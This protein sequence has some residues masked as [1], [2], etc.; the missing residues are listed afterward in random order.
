MPYLRSDD[1]P[2][3]RQLLVDFGRRVRRARRHRGFSQEDLERRSRVDQTAIS[4]LERGLAP[5]MGARRLVRLGDALGP[6]L[7]LG[8]CPHDHECA[9]SAP[10]IHQ[11]A[12]SDFWSNRG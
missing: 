2:S 11:R 1:D 10:E 5:A 4:R 7:P 8:Y 3:T 6:A 12:L 9:W